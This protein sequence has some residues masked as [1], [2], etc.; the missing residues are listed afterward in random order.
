MTEFC[1]STPRI[2]MQRCL[3][4]MTTAT[5]DG[6][7]ACMSASAICVVSCSWICKP[8]R[9]DIDDARDFGKADHFSVGDIGHMRFADE[10]EQMMLAHRI[11]LD[12]FDQN[13]LARVGSRR[14]PR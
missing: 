5:P 10:R 8:A 1:F 6:C 13:D 7:S 14:S 9:E 11:K 12:V 3:A 2:I 4:S